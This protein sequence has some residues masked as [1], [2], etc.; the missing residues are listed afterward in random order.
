MTK[1]RRVVVTG[2]AAVC[3]LGIEADVIWNNITSGKTSIKYLPEE[4]AH[5]MRVK[6]AG[7]V[8]DEFVATDYFS[9]KDLKKL[10]PSL[11]YGIVASRK[12]VAMSKLDQVKDKERVGVSIGSGIGGLEFIEATAKVAAS[13]GSRRVS[14]YFIPSTIINEISG[15]A[16]IDYG[17]KGPNIA[18]VTAC[19]TGT[20]NIGIGARLIAYG[21]AD[22]MVVGGSEHAT[23]MLS[24]S[25]FGNMKALSA[26]N[27]DP[28]H[29]SRPFDKDRDGFVLSNGAAVLVIEELEHALARNANILCELTGFGMNGDAHH[30]TQP[31]TTGAQ[32]ENVM[33]LALKDAQLQ[34]T[35]VDYINAHGTS[36]PFNDLIESE[37][38][39][40]VFNDH[41][42]AVSSTKSMLGHMLGATGA[43]E[44]MVCCKAI[45]TG[46][47]PP[48]I[49]C[50]D[51]D[52]GK[53]LNIICHNSVKREVK[54]ALS[55]SFGFGGTNACLVFSKFEDNL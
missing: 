12:A 26:R 43:I 20:H 25:G 1:A 42:V 29:A 5:E 53:D 16:S 2:Y 44:A 45:E 7:F 21:D 36:T 41:D 38:I 52:V 34:P 4:L 10:D 17:F 55:N 50:F 47:V 18:V 24:M 3:P 6:F 39:K 8:S 22:A 11:Q 40:R 49:N 54:H 35:D 9:K 33:R 32:A 37:A 51:R 30:A 19:T 15:M 28:S 27:D 31:D 46:V 23:T 48:T 13:G 14:P